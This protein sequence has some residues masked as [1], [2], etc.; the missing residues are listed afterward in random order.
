MTFLNKNIM[1][2]K[3]EK[4]SFFEVEYDDFNDFV[5]ETYGGGFEFVAQHEGNNYSAYEF[6][7]PN[8]AMFFGDEGKDIRNG[9][10][11]NHSVHMIIQ[12]LFED[13]LIEE[14]EYLIKVSW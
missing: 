4:K 8:V 2:L 1:K 14:G 11:K 9:E 7:A 6:S 10:Y 12:C 5:N 3:A 13:G